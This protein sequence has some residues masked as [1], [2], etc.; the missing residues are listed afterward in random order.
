MKD[1]RTFGAPFKRRAYQARRVGVF[2]SLADHDPDVDGIY[3]LTQPLPFTFP[4]SSRVAA[5]RAAAS[6]PTAVDSGRQLATRSAMMSGG[7]VAAA[8]GM[9]KGMAQHS[10]TKP[11]GKSG[12]KPGMNQ[13]YQTVTL[14][15]GTMMPYNAQVRSAPPRR[16]SARGATVRIAILRP[17]DER[18]FRA[19]NPFGSIGQPI[20]SGSTRH[21]RDGSLPARGAVTSFAGP[22][23][24]IHRLSLLAP[25]PRSKRPHVVSVRAVQATLHAY[26]A[27]WGLLLPC[28]VHGRVTDI[29][30]AYFTQRLLWDI[31]YRIGFSTPWVT[32]YRNA[33]NYLADV[34]AE[35]KAPT[36]GTRVSKGCKHLISGMCA[37]MA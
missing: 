37:A 34:P 13:A 4:P 23:N 26:D 14:R 31:G 6:A 32:Q 12:R 36:Q 28:T 1:N 29:W 17:R 7:T 9:A 15:P 5:S 35:C 2:Q 16:L 30:R 21:R 19:F 25:S 18:N 22:V 10:G 3:R 24:W 11:V 20:R 8:K 33:H 27:L